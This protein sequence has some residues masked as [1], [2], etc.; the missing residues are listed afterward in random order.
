MNEELGMKKEE[1]GGPAVTTPPAGSFFLGTPYSVPKLALAAG[2]LV[3]LVR[4]SL[5]GTGTMAFIDERRYI[6]AMLGLRSLSE[7]H[8]LDFLQAINSMGARPADGLW[9]AIPGLGQALLL[10]VFHLNPNSPAS[11]QVPQVFN[12]LIMGLN[13]GLLYRIYR[14]FFTAS[15][16]LLGVAL[17]ASLT[18]TNLYVR[19]LLPYDHSLFFFLVSLW[20]LLV[21]PAPSPRRY[22]WVGVLSGFSYALYPGYF[23]GTLLLLGLCMARAVA[24]GMPAGAHWAYSRFVPV[25][26]QLAGLV[27]VLGAF[28]LLARLSGTSYLASSRYI[29][30]TVTQG[31]FAEGFSFIGTYFWQVEGWMGVGLLLLFAIG[32]VLCTWQVRCF[33]IAASVQTPTILLVISFLAWLGYA[34]LVQFGHKLVF[35][36]RILHFF[37]PFVVL[38]AVV[39][40][41]GLAHRWPSGQK[42]V[43]GIGAGLALWHFGAFVLSY[44]AVLY[45][46]DVAYSHGILD[47][48]QIVR[49]KTTSCSTNLIAYRTFGPL[50]RDQCTAAYPQYEVVNFAYLYPL[51]CYQPIVKDG[52]K[53]IASVPYFMKYP[54]YQFEGHGPTERAL[55]RKYPCDFQIISAK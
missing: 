10:A 52:R 31:S 22:W 39:A 15:F 41:R 9:R 54:A 53:L 20:L 12:V 51:G 50:I 34:F 25:A 26:V 17:Y 27:A 19:H 42:A 18:N 28:E 8:G 33:Q 47:S 11:L 36:G 1:L 29:A 5:V 38:G 35:Y 37:V 24:P 43:L 13:L 45:P 7:G 21:S 30:T 49:A 3:T 2:M 6:T 14:Q 55:L 23:M 16:A 4:L 46:C 32:L 44:R 48:R 40:L